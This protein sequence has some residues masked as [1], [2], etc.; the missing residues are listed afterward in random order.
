MSFFARIDWTLLLLAL[1][2]SIAGLITMQSYGQ[3]SI[4]FDRQLAWL[5]IAVGLFFFFALLDSSV[6]KKTNAR[7]S[8]WS[9]GQWREELVFARRIFGA[10]F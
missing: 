10:T 9:Y 6:L 1:P 4:F 7:A 3:G 8:H 5:A 2:I